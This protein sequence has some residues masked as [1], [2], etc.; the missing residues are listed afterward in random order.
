MK[1]IPSISHK[2]AASQ[3][4]GILV[5][6]GAIFYVRVVGHS[7]LPDFFS[8]S[9]NEGIYELL[10]RLLLTMMILGSIVV[11]LISIVNYFQVHRGIRLL[12]RL[13]VWLLFTNTILYRIY[14]IPLPHYVLN[15]CFALGFLVE[16]ILFYLE[17]RVKEK[18][19]DQRH[20]P[21]VTKD[22]ALAF[23]SM[24]L[25]TM[26]QADGSF[27]IMVNALMY[28]A[29]VYL[30]LKQRRNG[31]I[32]PKGSSYLFV[33]MAVFAILIQYVVSMD[34]VLNQVYLMGR[35]TVRLGL[36]LLMYLPL[37]KIVLQKKNRNL[38]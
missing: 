19:E 23:I 30:I 24:I 34:I 10:V 36:Y 16:I 9:A 17:G 15:V 5:F 27:G 13:Y 12:L 2:K 6:Y 25:L 32:T 29:I 21:H 31:I 3:L 7:T 4:I 20:R 1:R 26:F 35:T 18:R 8:S 33:W 14:A 11:E 38:V 22:L 37:Y 28:L